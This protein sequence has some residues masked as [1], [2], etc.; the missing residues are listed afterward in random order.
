M[1]ETS[2]RPIVIK[3]GGSTLGAEDTTL[4]DVVAHLEHVREVAGIDHIGIGSDYDGTSE[5]PVGMEDVAGYPQLF[6]E[7]IRRG[8][9]DADLLKLAGENVLRVLRAVE[10][11]RDRL[12]GA[13]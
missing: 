2:K 10:R 9:N 1:S 7:L 8:W 6:A 4:D 13:R 3:I 11:E 12:A 5:L